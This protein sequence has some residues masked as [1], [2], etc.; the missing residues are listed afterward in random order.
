MKQ[1]LRQAS[2]LMEELESA[3]DELSKALDSDSG[4]WQRLHMKILNIQVK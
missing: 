4:D 2:I 1:S 3:K